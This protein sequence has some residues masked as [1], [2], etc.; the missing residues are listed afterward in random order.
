MQEQEV[1]MVATP[2]VLQRL[3]V[4]TERLFRLAVEVKDP[5][6]AMSMGRIIDDSIRAI[7]LV[8]TT[9]KPAIPR[10]MMDAHETAVADVLEA[11]TQG[12]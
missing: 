5:H 2:E 1:E 6:D 12:T 10:K 7:Q 4:A 9:S 3:I 8:R 11:Y